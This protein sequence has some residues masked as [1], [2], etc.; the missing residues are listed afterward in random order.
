MSVLFCVPTVMYP[1]SG[2]PLLLVART[3]VLPIESTLENEGSQVEERNERRARSA[4]PN[5]RGRRRAVL[6]PRHP[7]GGNGCGARSVGTL[8][9]AD[10]LGL[11]VEGRSG[12]RGAD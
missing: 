2:F 8:A 10:L 11:P 3:I 4:R 9:Q 12:R 6:R 1:M 7:R 5:R